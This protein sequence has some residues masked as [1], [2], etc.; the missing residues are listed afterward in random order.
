VE[1]AVILDAWQG[2]SQA[3]FNPLPTTPRTNTE[4]FELAWEATR[5]TGTFFAREQNRYNAYARAGETLEG[6]GFRLANP[7]A[8]PGGDAREAGLQAWRDAVAQARAQFPDRAGEFMGPEEVER[9]ADERAARAF[10][11]NRAAGEVGGGGF[12]GFL[13]EVAGTLSDP[14]QLATLPLG[15]PLRIGGSV[16][17]R[18]LTTALIEGGVAGATQLAVEARAAPYRQSIGLP[19]EFGEN[20]LAATAGGAVLGGGMRALVEGWRLLRGRAPA[21]DGGE[22]LA[23]R[24]AAALVDRARRDA[25]GN[26]G[27]PAA[28]AQHEMALDDAT[29]AVAAGRLPADPAVPTVYEQR[30]AQAV[31]DGAEARV[32]TASGRAVDV[33]YQVVE[34]R[35][36]I[37]SH[38]DDGALNAAYPHAEG[39]QPRD[40]SREASQAQIAD[41]AAK[42]EPSR[43]GPSSEA[44]TGAPIVAGDNVVESGNGRVLALRRVYGDPNLSA[45]AAAYRAFL[46]A[47][48]HDVDG[49]EAPML[50]ARRVSAL[51]PD[52]RRAWVKEANAETSLTMS[53]AE[54]ARADADLA[55]RAIGLFQGGDV[56]DAR[57]AAFVRAFVSGLPQ[58][59]QGRMTAAGGGLSSEG[60]RR[61]RAAVLARAYGDEMGPLLERILEGDAEGL[62]AIAGALQDVSARWA[63]M[64]AAAAADEIAPGMDVTADLLA[65]VRTVDTARQK[66]I[67]VAD[68]VAQADLEL[69]PLSDTGRALLA[70]MFRD[71]QFR[72]RPVG[73]ETLAER[74]GGY[75]DEAMKSRPGN[76]LFGAPP[77]TG[78]E[79]LEASDPMR[80][81]QRALADTAD[82][83][84]AVREA[85]PRLAEA[86]VLEAQRVAAA[87][88]L[89]VPVGTG[90][91]VTTRSARELLDEADD[92][93]AN[94]AAAAVCMIGGVAA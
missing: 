56:A 72:G 83:E 1:R 26:P 4:R 39:V 28:A 19:S 5:Q 38:A 54:Q 74:L 7:F 65:A 46:K 94:A 87:R 18:I 84:A 93:V 69:P 75:V 89:Q 37:P 80:G 20:V 61:I 31:A 78:R 77:P 79:V 59:A 58:T 30:R 48:G 43:L 49:M 41:I 6:A 70:A 45:Q 21:L 44:A 91:A 29:R 90:D 11:D 14:V 88:D 50:V 63:A 52:E 53:A 36:L 24:D 62:K 17:T 76:D 13:G 3:A 40:R 9:D 66:G 82:A 15:A 81:R 85:T 47:G 32:F 25:E 73:R 55:G 33:Q 57:N 51:T 10:R 86:E 34:L 42:L 60:A 92:E 23:E 67:A 68:L 2:Q 27:G 12:G 22:A 64:R 71:P 35:S 16:A 8:L